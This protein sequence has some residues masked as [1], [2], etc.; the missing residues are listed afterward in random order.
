MNENT[1]GTHTIDEIILIISEVLQ[2]SDR[3]RQRMTAE[4]Q[5]LGAVPEF[6]SMAVVSVI[7][8]LEEHYGFVIDDDEV[9]ASTFETVG[10]LVDFV[11][12]KLL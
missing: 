5:L 2:L 7:T 4:T 12:G 10:S 6:D 3:V 8:A 9:E 11:N 1:V